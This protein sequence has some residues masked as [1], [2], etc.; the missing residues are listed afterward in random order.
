[1]NKT[2]DMRML[3]FLVFFFGKMGFGFAQNVNAFSEVTS[4]YKITDDEAEAL[5]KLPTLEMEDKY[6][7]TFVDTF[8]TNRYHKN[9]SLNGH[10]LFV[11][12]VN[13]ELNVL[14]ESFLTVSA[15]TLNNRRDLTIQVIDSLGKVIENAEVFFGKKKLK[16]DKS[17]QAFR[18]KKTNKGG[19]L[20]VKANSE[21]VFYQVNDR[22]KISVFK[23]RYYLS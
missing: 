14:L 6:F 18:K 20:K 19:F 23:K 7:H 2:N 1:M 12:A 11:K 13:D 4:I 15:V 9:E 10:Y 21:T 16:Y 22:E 3:L 5:F 17:I 8:S